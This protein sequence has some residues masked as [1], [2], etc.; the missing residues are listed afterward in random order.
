MFDPT[1][2]SYLIFA[3][4]NAWEV[5]EIVCVHDWMMDVYAEIF[6]KCASE[7]IR[8]HP[9]REAYMKGKFGGY[10]L[11]FFLSRWSQKLAYILIRVVHDHYTSFSITFLRHVVDSVSTEDRAL[12]LRDYFF[13]LGSHFSMALETEPYD[14]HHRTETKRA[15]ERGRAPILWRYS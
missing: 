7:L 6:R 9:S 1:E 2:M 3:M 14:F 10:I 13:D 5:E 4:L 15:Y 12:L 11:D 8:I